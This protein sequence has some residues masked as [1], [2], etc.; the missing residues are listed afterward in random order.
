VTL[1]TSF[2]LVFG[3]LAERLLAPRTATETAGAARPTPVA[4]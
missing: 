4:H 3:L 2:G 1:W